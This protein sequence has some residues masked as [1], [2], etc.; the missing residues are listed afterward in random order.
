M[1]GRGKAHLFV[2]TATAACIEW[3]TARQAGIL[4]GLEYPALARAEGILGLPHDNLLRSPWLDD[5]V[6]ALLFDLF[7]VNNW[8]LRA[9]GLFAGLVLAA[10]AFLIGWQGANGE[11]NSKLQPFLAWGCGLAFLS[12]AAVD[13]HIYL[14]NG[15]PLGMLAMVVAWFALSTLAVPRPN[16]I[17]MATALFVAACMA[18]ACAGI[19]AWFGV[20]LPLSAFAL[21]PALSRPTQRIVALVALAT[22]AASVSLFCTQGEGFISILGA[23]KELAAL[24]GSPNPTSRIVSELADDLWPWLGWIA[25]ATLAAP[26]R[27]SDVYLVRTGLVW[28]AGAALWSTHY[29]P[30]S[31]GILPLWP[32]LAWRGLASFFDPDQR[33]NELS[34]RLAWMR[35]NAVLLLALTWVLTKHHDFAPLPALLGAQASNV[36]FTDPVFFD[37]LRRSLHVP[38]LA[39]TLLAALAFLGARSHLLARRVRLSWLAIAWIALSLTLTTLV[40]PRQRF[41]LGRSGGYD[42][43]FEQWRELLNAGSIGTQLAFRNGQ[44]PGFARALPRELEARELRSQAELTKWLEGD[45]P[46]VALVSSHDLAL[47]DHRAREQKLSFGVLAQ[48]RHDLF[49]VT[50]RSIDHDN[51]PLRSVVVDE[52]PAS[53]HPTRVEFD[54]RVALVGWTLNSPFRRGARAH[55]TLVFEVLGTLPPGVEIIVRLQRGRMGRLGGRAEKA[56]QGI[57]PPSLWR[58]GEFI[59]H[60]TQIEV[61]WILTVP[62]TYELLIAVKKIGG[63]NFPVTSTDEDLE[64]V[65]AH[66]RGGKREFVQIATLD[67]E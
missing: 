11:K 54:Q 34:P 39:T 32:L 6:R 24:H 56:A 30:L 36:N 19:G 31:V 52:P 9:N 66:S 23:A 59:I 64:K 13:R 57:Y 4:P 61:P 10:L 5:A 7:G 67:I 12:G 17:R 60:R 28:I 42:H 45:E 49:F 35:W 2:F 15:Q 41:E 8:T 20:V 50:N 33:G 25:V 62:G 27:E 3:A 26:R 53:E 63:N 37:A 43:V 1:A 58:R 46:R 55:L 14:A 44:E 48:A 40:I 22:A 51:N 18:L 29:P 47:L 16:A 21:H 38:L 65:K